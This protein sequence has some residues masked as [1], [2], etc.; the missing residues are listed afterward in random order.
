M[1]MNVVKDKR[2]WMALALLSLLAAGCASVVTFNTPK[3][4]SDQKQVA[5]PP[6]H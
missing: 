3:E 4:F 6:L 5:D 1:T 2:A